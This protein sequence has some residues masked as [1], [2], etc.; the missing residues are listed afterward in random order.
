MRRNIDILLNEARDRSVL[1]GMMRGNM[2]WIFVR[3]CKKMYKMGGKEAEN[4]TRNLYTRNAG[5]P[6]N[7]TISSVFCTF[8]FK[9]GIDNRHQKYKPRQYIQKAFNEAYYVSKK[10]F[11]RN[12]TF[13]SVQYQA[14]TDLTREQPSNF[15]TYTGTSSLT[16]AW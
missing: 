4:R 9:S 3:F 14:T 13:N 7:T 15:Y 8:P 16:L 6:C 5:Q 1:R 12:S 11:K 10:L 2:R